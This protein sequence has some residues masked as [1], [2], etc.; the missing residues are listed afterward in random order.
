MLL[1]FLSASAVSAATFAVARHFKYAEIGP[2]MGSRCGMLGMLGREG[3]VLRRYD[4]NVLG[5]TLLGVGMGLTGACPGTVLVQAVAG[6]RGSVVLLGSC[7]LGGSMFVGWERR[8]KPLSGAR[9][10][11]REAVSVAEA[12][13]WSDSTMIVAYEGMLAGIVL[14]TD[15]FGPRGNYLVNPMVG[16]LLIGLAQLLSVVVSKKSLGVSSA[17]EDAGRMLWGYFESKKTAIGMDNFAFVGGVLIG[18]KLTMAM[19]PRT[20]E[21]FSQSAD[22]S[23]PATIFGG[24]AMIF[25]SRIAGGCTSGHGISGM[26]SLGISSFITVACMFSGGILTAM[27]CRAVS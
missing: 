1:T 18:A 5:G 25:G 19:V 14:P 23:L 3:G 17:Y 20:M 24:I 27:L 22:I 10:G 13:G 6:V 11:G 21:V 9:E 8:F 4:G 12:L 16:G 7:V 26:S 2:R 15:R